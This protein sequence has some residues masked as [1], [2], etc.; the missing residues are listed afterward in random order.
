MHKLPP[1]CPLPLPQERTATPKFWTIN[2]GQ[3]ATVGIFALT[4]V[5]ATSAFTTK[6]TIDGDMLKNQGAALTTRVEAA[7]LKINNLDKQNA[8]IEKGLEYIRESLD[9]IERVLSAAPP[10]K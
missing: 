5:Y 2:V 9:R 7:E 6:S 4:L 3:L 1:D 8:V 10:R